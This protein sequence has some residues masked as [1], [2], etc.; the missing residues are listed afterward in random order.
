MQTVYVDLYFLINFSMDFLC[1]FLAARLLSQRL[2]LP[3][4]LLASALGGIYANIALFLPVSALAALLID[5]AVCALL[6]AVALLRPHEGRRLPLFVLVYVATSMV[7]GGVMT[8]LFHLFNR[9][10]LPISD[11]ESD[12]I[13]VWLLAVL[14]LISAL[15][16]R[17]CGCLFARRAGRR[18]ATVTIAL[19]GRIRTLTALCDTGN[20]LREP[21]S[22]KPCIVVDCDRLAG[23]LS[24]ELLASARAERPPDASLL[25]QYATRIRLVPAYA[26]TGSRPLLALRVDHVTVGDKESP[27]E[28]DALVVLSPL[29]GTADALI[30]PELLL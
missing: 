28:V 8:A 1:F 10:A 4:T 11:I 18:E 25:A 19:D 21:I 7:L 22:G 14:V 16:T 26:A 2:S 24:E 30:P 6:C 29:R 13:S 12:G 17:L 27:H 3:R 5:M 23:F 15:L 20:Q 9:L